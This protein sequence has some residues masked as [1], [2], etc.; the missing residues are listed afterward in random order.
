M[1]NYKKLKKGQPLL[2]PASVLCYVEPM[3][4]AK[5]LRGWGVYHLVDFYPHRR[6]EM[7]VKVRDNP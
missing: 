1:I 4:D 2:Y 6:D 3:P 7:G 5:G